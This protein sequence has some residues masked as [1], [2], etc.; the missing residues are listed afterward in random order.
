MSNQVSNLDQ[1]RRTTVNRRIPPHNSPHTYG[2][3]PQS[4]SV[5]F[6]PDLIKETHFSLAFSL[7]MR[8]R[9][10]RSGASPL[11]ISFPTS[12]NTIGSLIQDF[13]SLRNPYAHLDSGS[14]NQ[15][16]T[17]I[18][19]QQYKRAHTRASC[20]SLSSYRSSIEAFYNPSNF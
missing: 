19:K 2:S 13:S 6:Q 20:L 12:T 7:R 8:C 18:P 1:T 11:G 10:F 15:P 3:S 14:S 4:G 16:S 17:A 5:L 9:V